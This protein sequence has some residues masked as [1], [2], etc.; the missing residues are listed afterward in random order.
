MRTASAILLSL[1]YFS[2]T[3]EKYLENLTLNN[4]WFSHAF[5][6]WRQ[7]TESDL[8]CSLSAR[9]DLENDKQAQGLSLKAP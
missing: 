6:F 2:T 4:A 5:L 8:W 3:V 9:L 1:Q 7:I